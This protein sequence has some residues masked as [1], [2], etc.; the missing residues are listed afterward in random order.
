LLNNIDELQESGTPL[1]ANKL[2]EILDKYIQCWVENMSQKKIPQL[3]SF[4]FHL[5][6]L[7]A[8]SEEDEIDESANKLFQRTF[9]VQRKAIQQYNIFQCQSTSMQMKSFLDV[10]NENYS[11]VL[12][13]VT[14]TVDNFKGVF[15]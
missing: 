14:G 12:V 11:D 4:M 15:K 1:T 5:V 2:N 9:H 13:Q 8:H 3:K 7:R 10:K 6:R